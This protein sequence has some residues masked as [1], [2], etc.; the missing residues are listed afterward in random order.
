VSVTYETLRAMWPRTG[1]T[2]SFGM[3]SLQRRVNDKTDPLCIDPD[4]QR[5]RA[6]TDDQCARFIGF[7]A[8]GGQAPV[9]WVQRWAYSS[10]KPDEL[11]DGLQRVTAILR[12]LNNEVPMELTDGTRMYLRD[13][14]ERDQRMITSSVSGPNV[15]IQYVQYETR[16]EVLQLYLRLN[17]GGTVHTEAEIERVRALLAA[18]P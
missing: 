1:G 15:T 14:S 10:G 5:G 3:L 7:L 9:L 8:E 12:F 11:L 16:A 2:E 4:Y 6:W 13:L 18:E 17:R